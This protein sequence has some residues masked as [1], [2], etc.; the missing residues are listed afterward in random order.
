MRR[1]PA[2]P[3]DAHVGHARALGSHFDA[4]ERPR[5][6]ARYRAGGGIH[7]LVTSNARRA[8]QSIRRPMDAPPDAGLS[9]AER[10]E[11]VRA[12]QIRARSVGATRQSRGVVQTW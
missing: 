12:M 10:E 8:R 1:L 11:I 4:D 3:C 2:G 6:N 9:S 7:Y 5:R